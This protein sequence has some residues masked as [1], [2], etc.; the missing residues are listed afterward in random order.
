M[1]G[2]TTW[3]HEHPLVHICEQPFQLLQELLA[4]LQSLSLSL[5]PVLAASP[6]G[7]TCIQPGSA[8]CLLE[9]TCGVPFHQGKICMWHLTCTDKPQE[10]I[11]A[12]HCM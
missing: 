2:Q 6:D 9:P 1:L 7:T 10:K 11:A 3:G 4:D 8:A 5:P 12:A